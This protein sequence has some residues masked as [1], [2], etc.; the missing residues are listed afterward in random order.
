M[1]KIGPAWRKKEGGG[2]GCDSIWEPVRPSW[3]YET[4]YTAAGEQ[5]KGVRVSKCKA[6]S[7]VVEATWGDKLSAWRRCRVAVCCG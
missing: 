2:G 5:G 3:L 4:G 7:G 6:G 1:A